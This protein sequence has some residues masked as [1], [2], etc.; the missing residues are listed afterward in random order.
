MQITHQ[1]FA[2]WTGSKR[3]CSVRQQGNLHTLMF[4]SKDSLPSSSLAFRVYGGTVLRPVEAGK[5]C[6]APVMSSRLDRVPMQWSGML[7]C[8][9]EIRQLPFGRESFGSA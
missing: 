9:V 4:S 3:P 6:L 1:A 2:R 8:S 5:D 7:P